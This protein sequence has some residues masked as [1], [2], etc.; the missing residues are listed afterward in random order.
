MLFSLRKPKI[1]FIS[2]TSK[3]PSVLRDRLKIASLVCYVLAFF[4]PAFYG[5]SNLGVHALILGVLGFV[6]NEIF[7][8]I[9]W[10]AN[11]VYFLSVFLS[12]KK[13][14]LRYLLSIIAVILAL[15]VLG[16]DRIPHER[17][18]N[19]LYVM[20]GFGAMLWIASMVLNVL[21]QRDRYL[22]MHRH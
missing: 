15:G 11:P 6:E 13:R 18:G 1:N 20:P 12:P 14:K 2:S 16:I 22:S 3:Y 17:S 4:I 8:G 19:F 5:S 9:V 21:Y 10:L 7:I